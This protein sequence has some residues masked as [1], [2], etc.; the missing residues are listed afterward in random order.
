MG[1]GA[2]RNLYPRHVP[3]LTLLRQCQF[4]ERRR[5]LRASVLMTIGMALLCGGIETTF[6]LTV[7]QMSHEYG[8]KVATKSFGVLSAI[9]VSSAVF[10][11]YYEIYRRKAVMG[12]SLLVLGLDMLGG[13]LNDLSL[14]FSE[15]FDALAAVSYSAV[16]VSGRLSY[17]LDLMD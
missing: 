8:K 2:Q 1:P 10:P 4:Y 6:V 15:D 3:A 5:S 7:R 13:L 11:Q 12:I 9:L 14:V 16:I 17:I